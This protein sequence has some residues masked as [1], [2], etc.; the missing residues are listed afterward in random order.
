MFY[1]YLHVLF[2]LEPHVSELRFAGFFPVLRHVDTVLR[3]ARLVHHIGHK[4]PT[5]KHQHF[6]RFIL[7]SLL[8]SVEILH[9]EAL[10]IIQVHPIKC[11]Y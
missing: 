2:L 9:I 5:G 8:A 6:S 1:I 3:D 11:I 10:S 4:L 7:V